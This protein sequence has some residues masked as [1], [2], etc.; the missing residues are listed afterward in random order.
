MDQRW[1]G[2]GWFK[3]GKYYEMKTQIL[4]VLLIFFCLFFLSFVCVCCSFHYPY[5]FIK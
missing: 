1:S 4:F 2:K 3:K 5:T